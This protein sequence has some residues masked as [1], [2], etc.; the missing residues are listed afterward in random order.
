MGTKSCR[1]EA[2]YLKINKSQQLRRILSDFLRAYEHRRS[3]KLHAWFL[4]IEIS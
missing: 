1:E 2:A 4:G 3:Y